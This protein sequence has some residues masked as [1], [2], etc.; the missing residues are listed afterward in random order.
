MQYLYNFFKAGFFLLI[1]CTVSIAAQ[2]QTKGAYGSRILTGPKGA[3]MLLWGIGQE[4]SKKVSQR[5][6]SKERL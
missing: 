5:F 3:V 1:L 6:P 4:S 2:T